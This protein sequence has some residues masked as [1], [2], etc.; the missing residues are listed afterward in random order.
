MKIIIRPL[1]SGD[2]EVEIEPNETVQNLKAIINNK[3]DLPAHNQR[4]IFAGKQ[5][6]DD[7]TMKSIGIEDGS[8]IHLVRTVSSD[9]SDDDDSENGKSNFGLYLT[10]GI[11]A[12]AVILLT[13]YLLKKKKKQ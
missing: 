13:I 4:L 8:C 6:K 2:C 3:I 10:L 12:T 9:S 1:F 5:L 7:Q 11:G